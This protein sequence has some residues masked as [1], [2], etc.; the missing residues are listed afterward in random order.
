MEEISLPSSTPLKE[1]N[2]KNAMLIFRMFNFSNFFLILQATVRET[3][4]YFSPKPLFFYLSFVSGNTFVWQMAPTA[5]DSLWSLPGCCR[6]LALGWP[7]PW[8]G[9]AL[10]WCLQGSSTVWEAAAATPASLGNGPIY[11]IALPFAIPLV[12]PVPRQSIGLCFQ[13]R[14]ILVPK[15]EVGSSKNVVQCALFLPLK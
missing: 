13:L 7:V 9:D 5:R 1:K 11:K 10:G 2:S 15:W 14:L 4:K 3:Y 12:T 8:A 6:S